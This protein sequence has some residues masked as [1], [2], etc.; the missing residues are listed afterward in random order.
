MPVPRHAAAPVMF[1]AIY[2]LSAIT[3][4]DCTASA[5]PTDTIRPPAAYGAGSIRLEA[6]QDR[7]RGVEAAVGHQDCPLG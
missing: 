1:T 5:M 4:V 6:T 2:F 3:L 7:Q